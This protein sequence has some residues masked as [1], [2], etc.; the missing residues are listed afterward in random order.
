MKILISGICGFVGRRLAEGLLDSAADKVEIIGI[1]N[2]IRPGAWLNREGLIARGVKIIH[3]DIRQAS[4]IETVG[5]MDWVLDAAA[6]PSVLAGVDGKS[7]SR[8]LLEHNLV[9]TINLLE[10]CK[11]YKAGFILLST[12]RVYGIEPLAALKVTAEN[13]A[14]V[15]S[16]KQELPVGVSPAGIAET[17]TTAPPISLYGASKSASETLAL[18]YG[19]VFDFPVWINRCGVLAGAGQ[20]GRA[21]QGIFSF[22]IHSWRAK[23]PLKY[24]GF[25]GTG[26]QVRDCLHPLDLVPLLNKQMQGADS[27]APRVVNFGG[28]AENSMSLKQLSDWCANRFG[29]HDVAADCNPRPFDLPWIV[30]N[31]SLAGEVWDWRPEMRIGAVLEEIAK[32][33]EENPEW[34]ALSAS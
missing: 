18:E 12:S 1:D 26:H 23:R 28:G 9:G 32:H 20:F 24:I 19:G 4:D 8:Q 27:G 3:G 7:S 29:P 16:P 22:W 11:A 33:A 5:P 13:D 21:D 2:L 10:H 34:L 6:N 31:S 15:P 14:F 17:Y 25:D 30:M